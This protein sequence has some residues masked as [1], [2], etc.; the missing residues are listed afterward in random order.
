[1][2]KYCQALIFTEKS[3]DANIAKIVLFMKNSNR[4]VLSNPSVQL[5]STE[6]RMT[7]SRSSL[8]I[9]VFFFMGKEAQKISDKKWHVYFYL[10][11]VVRKQDIW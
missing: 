3:F 4:P 6:F 10:V 5:N 2:T 1:M 11:E 9:R 7:I 8:E